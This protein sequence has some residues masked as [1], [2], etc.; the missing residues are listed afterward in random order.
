MAHLGWGNARDKTGTGTPIPPHG[1]SSLK[2]PQ[3][4]N[5]TPGP[6]VRKAPEHPAHDLSLSVTVVALA[7]HLAGQ[8]ATSRQVARLGSPFGPRHTDH[9]REG[10]GGPQGASAHCVNGLLGVRPSPRRPGS[11]LSFRPC[12]DF[13][14]RCQQSTVSTALIKVHPGTTT[15]STRGETGLGGRGWGGNLLQNPSQK[16]AEDVQGRRPGLSMQSRGSLSAKDRCPRHPQ[17]KGVCSP[18]GRVRWI[19]V[20]HSCRQHNPKTDG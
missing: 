19:L 17:T 4:Q 7:R 1:S 12:G 10:V 13:A 8:P 18:H 15:C 11:H 20:A 14:R 6:G 9:G 2:G 3:R 5:E 16:A